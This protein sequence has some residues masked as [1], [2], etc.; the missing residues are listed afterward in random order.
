MHTERNDL[1][2]LEADITIIKDS[3]RANSGFIRYVIAAPALGR[4]MVS[5]GI[6]CFVVP[7][8][9]YF[10]VVR[11]GS[12]GTIPPAITIVLSGVSV[13]TLVILGLWKVA[14]ISRAAR[15]LDP[16]YSW[17]G[18]VSD[19]SGHPVLYFQS[20]VT[21]LMV[22]VSV[23][24]VRSASVYL[25]PAVVAGGIGT[26][27]MLY[28]IAFLLQEY[29]PITI[30]LYLVAAVTILLP[31]VSPLLTFAVGFGVGFTLFGLYCNRYGRST[32]A[33]EATD[34]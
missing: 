22:F 8:M 21:F 11:Y 7:L 26:V 20:L 6:A 19:L 3:V 28:A 12:L 24:A 16:R 5:F 14:A 1:K 15:T 33:A 30:W 27:F 32:K 2:R 4:F 23:V 9:W 18:V 31:G 25:V 29:I 17:N 34:S 13:G 10:M